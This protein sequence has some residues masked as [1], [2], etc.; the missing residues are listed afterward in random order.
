MAI[1]LITCSA[2]G[3]KN[4]S[5]RTVCLSCGGNLGDPHED[6]GKDENEQADDLEHDYEVLGLKFG[7]SIEE[8]KQAYKDL[9]RVWHPDRF[10]HDPR[11]YEK[12]QEKLKEI[13]LAYKRL[14]SFRT[15]PHVIS[16]Y[17]DIER[18][19]RLESKRKQPELHLLSKRIPT[20]LFVI[21]V[22]GVLAVVLVVALRKN[23][24]KEDAKPT[25][26]NQRAEAGDGR[27]LVEEP[28]SIEKPL[29]VVPAQPLPSVRRSYRRYT[30]PC[31]NGHWIESVTDDGEIIKLED[32]SIWQVDATDTIDSALWLAMSDVIL[33][34]DKMINVDDNEKV[35]V[36]RLR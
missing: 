20:R 29:N 22:T 28:P 2:C 33:C 4:A 15:D 12:A 6:N 35:S 3:T 27:Y 18:R 14:S 5:Y 25:L 23:P 16:T 31:E 11:L 21:I 26:G 10:L 24:S 17:V 19:H 36:T 30:S 8:V 1:E 9:V 7:A 34:N 13:N 32:G